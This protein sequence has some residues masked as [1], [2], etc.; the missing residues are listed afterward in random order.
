MLKL[1]NS[2]I[3]IQSINYQINTNL[4]ERKSQTQM[5]INQSIKKYSFKHVKCNQGGMHT[6]EVMNMVCV[7]S[8]CTHRGLIC[9]ICR[10]ENH[11][12]HQVLPIKTF[13]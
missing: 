2:I 3:I 8:A 11:E 6:G 10:M 9:P 1:S 4:F 13:L 7:D 12:S 5:S